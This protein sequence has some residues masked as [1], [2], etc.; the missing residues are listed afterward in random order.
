MQLL[1]SSCQSAQPWHIY[2]VSCVSYGAA[3]RSYS[4]VPVLTQAA[5]EA[6]DLI[7]PVQRFHRR[8]VGVVQQASLDDIKEQAA[9]PRVTA[10]TDPTLDVLFV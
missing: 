3:V 5:N 2:A 4:T 6:I 1:D 10:D 9:V 7:Q 8:V